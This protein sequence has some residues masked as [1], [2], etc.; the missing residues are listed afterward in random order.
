MPHALLFEANSI[1]SY[2]FSSGRLRDVA[3]ASELLDR[4]TS[5]DSNLLDTVCQSLDIDKEVQFSRRAGGAFYAFSDSADAIAQ[6]KN[7]WTLTVQQWAP[8]LQYSLGTGTGEDYP[9]AFDKARRAL[10][11]DASRLRARL[12]AAAPVTERSARTGLAAETRGDKKDGDID[13]SSVR[14]KA[15]S[16]PASAGFL[17]RYSPEDA[18][19]NWNDWP[20]NLEMDAN[21]QDGGF[22]YVN[23]SQTIALIHADGN[24]LGQVLKQIRVAANADPVQ[25]ISYYEEFSNLVAE[26]TQRAAQA[27]TAEVLLPARQPQELL[28]ARPILLGGD[29]IIV[30]VRADLALKYCKVFS[31]AFESTSKQALKGIAAKGI[32]GLPERLTLGFGI[33]YM[34]ASQ[35]F[36]MAV[37]LAEQLM[38]AA[39]KSAKDINPNDPPASLSFYRVTSSMVDDY[40]SLVERTLSHRYVQ[41]DEKEE[42]F[43]STL[44]TYFF[45]DSITSEENVPLLENLEKLAALLGKEDMARGPT[46]QLMTLIG[47]A[48]DISRQRYRRWKQLLNDKNHDDLNEF[49]SLLCKLADGELHEELPYARRSEEGAEWKTPLGDALAIMQAGTPTNKEDSKEKVA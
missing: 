3:G 47:Q 44:G 5:G 6:L 12:P 14:F 40:T 8:G 46:R 30:L 1:Q 17:T 21:E 9:Q 45:Q 10:T 7:L 22:P 48:T 29:D 18:G 28:A 11:A 19:L 33:V 32:N 41:P 24:G 4:M 43:V 13:A 35:P 36:H 26:V 38:D 27:A 25:F 49:E 23:D 39:K 42:V 16:N 34:R 2:L 20:R 31:R 15:F 37:T